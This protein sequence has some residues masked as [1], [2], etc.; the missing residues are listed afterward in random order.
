M[1]H[2]MNPITAERIC[3]IS[4]VIRAYVTPALENNPL[5][6]ER[7]LT[8]SSCEEDNLPRILHSNRL[9]PQSFN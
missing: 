9:Y 7:D 4:R 8:N 3:G 5:W 1:P 6:H 2:K